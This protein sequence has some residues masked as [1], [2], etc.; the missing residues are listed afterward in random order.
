MRTACATTSRTAG[1]DHVHICT[2]I[3]SAGDVWF[4]KVVVPGLPWKWRVR[5]CV[6]IGPMVATVVITMT[7]S[8]GGSKGCGDGSAEAIDSGDGKLP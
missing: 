6:V 1:P 7:A 5:D 3:C 8:S 2:T 4:E